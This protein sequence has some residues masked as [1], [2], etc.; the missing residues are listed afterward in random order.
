MKLTT[1]QIAQIETTL[2][3]NDLEFD[4]VKIELTDHIA[5]E[6]E[7]LMTQNKLE[8]QQAFRE[9]FENWIEEL[10]P[11]QGEFWVSSRVFAPKLIM[12]KW[13]NRSKKM[14]FQILSISIFIVSLL[15]LLIDYNNDETILSRLTIAFNSMY[16]IILGM[17]VMARILIW[18]S[19]TATTFGFMMQRNFILA[20]LLMSQQ[21]ISGIEFSHF[22]HFTFID[23]VRL[24]TIIF[25]LVYAVLTIQLLLKHQAF[26][27]QLTAESR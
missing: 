19:K 26:V 18:Q 23:V 16:W 6:I 2:V 4:D 3:L 22:N 13:V 17:L 27:N 7:A 14:V 21:F 12:D 9:A 5:S 1:E 24:F 20:L 8:Y 25:P 10:R 15:S 11:L